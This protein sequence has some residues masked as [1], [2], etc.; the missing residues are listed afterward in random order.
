VLLKIDAE[1]FKPRLLGAMA[2]VLERHRPD[3]LIEVLEGVDKQLHALDCLA[4][5]ACYRL[6]T[7]GPSRRATLMADPVDRDWLLTMSPRNLMS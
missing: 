4:A 2:P 6:S 7:E 1:G 5:Y 3:L